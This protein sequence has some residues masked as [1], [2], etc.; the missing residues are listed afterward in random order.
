MIRRIWNGWPRWF[1][2]VSVVVLIAT[3]SLTL[4][5]RL[6]LLR[7]SRVVLEVRTL[8]PGMEVWADGRNLGFAPVEIDVTDRLHRDARSRPPGLGLIHGGLQWIA[9][10]CFGDGG[11]TRSSMEDTRVTTR[12]NF[13]AW[14]VGPVTLEIKSRD[15]GKAVC[16]LLSP[17]NQ[18]SG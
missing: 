4:F 1:R 12:W 13:G 8:P 16:S 2:F 17:F 18:I 10:S 14:E 9:S 5:V 7:P 3:L 11:G 15:S 6:N